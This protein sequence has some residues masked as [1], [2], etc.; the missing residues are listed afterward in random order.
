VWQ[1]SRDNCVQGR[2]KIDIRTLTNTW[3]DS[4]IYIYIYI[5]EYKGEL[6]MNMDFH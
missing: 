4:Y 3:K 5:C 6:N 2:D 1:I